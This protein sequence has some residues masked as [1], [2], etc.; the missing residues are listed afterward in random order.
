MRALIAVALVLGT[1]PADELAD[2]RKKLLESASPEERDFTALIRAVNQESTNRKLPSYADDPESTYGPEQ[3]AFRAEA[4]GPLRDDPR[5]REFLRTLAR[6]PSTG[7]WDT[8]SLTA[9]MVLADSPD[10]GDFSVIQEAYL[11]SAP[12][13]RGSIA[14]Q[15][16]RAIAALRAQPDASSSLLAQV[17]AARA[18]LRAD[19]AEG[20]AAQRGAALEGL[21]RAGDVDEAVAI[22]RPLL[23]GGGDRLETLTV[24]QACARLFKVKQ[25]DPFLKA[26]AIAAAEQAVGVAIAGEEEITATQVMSGKGRTL[27]AA[28]GFLQDA[29]GAAELDLLLR[30]LDDERAKK[31]LGMDGLQ[32]LRFALQQLRPKLPAEKAVA[33]DERFLAP[34]LADGN[35]LFALEE[36]PMDAAEKQAFWERRD[37]RYNALA[38]FCD[39]FMR[40]PT[41]EGTPPVKER[42]GKEPDLPALLATL[43][44][45]RGDE[46]EGDGP[47]VRFNAVTEKLENRVLSLQLL[48]LIQREW[49]RDPAGLDVFAEAYGILCG[50]VQAPLVSVEQVVAFRKAREPGRVLTIPVGKPPSDEYVQ[51]QAAQTL[52]DLGY[53]V[54]TGA[55]DIRIEVDAKLPWPWPE[56]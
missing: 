51:N 16:G 6:R 13:H 14:R 24:L 10:E 31:L 8:E 42:L 9:A 18:Q 53:I 2:A 50:E 22:L 39:Q 55:K 38:Y 3:L 40:K 33:L 32:N 43:Y 56:K 20:K 29:G 5:T 12:E 46:S 23:E 36:E 7:G 52:A 28:L 30:C 1:F 37:L 4:Y 21:F 34:L 25:L 11:G 54:W 17:D 27:R 47:D 44:H 49:N 48:A 35:R 41:G 45:A 26:R 19:A 15:L